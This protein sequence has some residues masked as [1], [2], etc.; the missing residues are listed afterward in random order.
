MTKRKT[1]KK[2]TMWPMLSFIVNLSRFI[3]TMIYSHADTNS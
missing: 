1:S 2:N 3:V